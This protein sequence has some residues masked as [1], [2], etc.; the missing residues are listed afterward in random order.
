MNSF[1]DWQVGIC[2]RRFLH[3]VLSGFVL[4]LCLFCS[5]A[6]AGWDDLIRAIG[7]L[8]VSKSELQSIAD[9]VTRFNHRS[10]DE[11]FD[12]TGVLKRP[13]SSAD[14]RHLFRGP[15]DSILPSL[16]DVRP[17][18]DRSF[19]E[20]EE[21]LSQMSR[22]TDLDKR[23]LNRV[24]NL[25]NQ[26]TALYDDDLF[27]VFRYLRAEEA[28]LLLKNGDSLRR[29]S[30]K[31]NPK[32]FERL[33]TSEELSYFKREFQIRWNAIED[34][35]EKNRHRLKSRLAGGA[36]KAKPKPR[37]DLL[38][39]F[40]FKDL[41][42]ARKEQKLLLMMVRR[43]DEGVPIGK[44]SFSDRVLTAFRSNELRA[45]LGNLTP[46]QAFNL[47]RPWYFKDPNL[48]SVGWMRPFLFD[49]IVQT[50]TD[51]RRGLI[52]TIKYKYRVGG[53]ILGTVGIFVLALTAAQPLAQL[54]IGGQ[55]KRLAMT[56]AQEQYRYYINQL[57]AKPRDH[58]LEKCPFCDVSGYMGQT[59]GH[60]IKK[61][62]QSLTNFWLSLYTNNASE[63]TDEMSYGRHSMVGLIKEILLI[64]NALAINQILDHVIK[65]RLNWEPSP[66]E[67]RRMLGDLNEIFAANEWLLEWAYLYPL[68]YPRS[69]SFMQS[70]LYHL[71]FQHFLHSNKDFARGQFEE[72]RD[73][74]TKQIREENEIIEKA[75]KA[76]LKV[77]KIT[78]DQIYEGLGGDPTTKLNFEENGIKI[79]FSKPL[80]STY[81]VNLEDYGK[82][83]EFWDRVR[84]NK[85]VIEILERSADLENAYEEFFANIS[86]RALERIRE[87]REQLEEKVE[88]AQP[89]VVREFSGKLNIGDD[90]WE[91][92]DAEIEKK[93]GNSEELNKV[94]DDHYKRV[95]G[96]ASQLVEK[97]DHLI[98]MNRLDQEN[99]LSLRMDY[100][101][102]LLE[103]VKGISSVE[104]ASEIIEFDISNILGELKSAAIDREVI[105]KQISEMFDLLKD[106][107]PDQILS[108]IEVAK[109]TLHDDHLDI[110][111]MLSSL[112]RQIDEIKKKLDKSE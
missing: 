58:N 19:D 97:I 6:Q 62:W 76:G 41:D 91:K 11:I 42:T 54:Y 47:R 60:E 7:H 44:V 64:R 80:Y 56:V 94:L 69:A 22:H 55:V 33:F 53:S 43:I 16:N 40:D 71:G 79:D 34:W 4:T 92:L 96:V 75:R 1:F 14:A 67:K 109:Q 15:G 12:A 101:V 48:R 84:G 51:F 104:N 10:Y 30:I 59:D 35:V 88:L 27:R 5:N 26:Y 83:E 85:D 103:I 23:A 77:E 93:V 108:Q 90:Y 57:E 46:D 63:V 110:K 8:K 102:R 9:L 2:V 18:F 95:E 24:R 87:Q 70:S 66:Q 36:V 86:T 21:I 81:K 45:S 61:D 89:G 39:E 98:E 50:Y 65:I 106:K 68:M 78:P 82:G 112:Q 52:W 73:F 28:S 107:V 32:K 72:I 100:D 74:L 25:A 31:I 38:R 20:L 29:S 3:K 13:L 49:D 105:K 37:H 111:E 99:Y 17:I